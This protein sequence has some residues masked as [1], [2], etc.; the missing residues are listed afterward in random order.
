MT[1]TSTPLRPRPSVLEPS[2]VAVDGDAFRHAFRRHAAGVAIVTVD[3]PSGP[4]G[5]T[6]TSLASVSLDPP[7]LSVALAGSSSVWPVAADADAFVVNLL[8]ASASGLATR[9]ATPGVDRFAPPTR[10][11][12][13]GSGDPYLLDAVGWLRCAV[14]DRVAVGDHHLVIGLV[15]ETRVVEVTDPLLYHDGNYGTR[16][17]LGA[18][19][20]PATTQDHPRR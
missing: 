15:T 19:E 1:S 6:V 16:T 18:P 12:R 2:T 14:V 9:F 4:V 3:A 7:L 17:T 11:D 13:L 5:C 20:A 8:G 10:W